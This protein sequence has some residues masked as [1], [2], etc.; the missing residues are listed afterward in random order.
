[1][2]VPF[3]HFFPIQPLYQGKEIRL[4]RE[5]NF[6]TCLAEQMVCVFV[7][8]HTLGNIPAAWEKGAHGNLYTPQLLSH[9]TDYAIASSIYLHKPNHSHFLHKDYLY[10][11][12]ASHDALQ[13]FHDDASTDNTHTI[14]VESLFR[15]RMPLV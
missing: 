6:S 11:Y 8:I 15:L 9:D 4:D 13:I 1:M 5:G 10:N 3:P 7:P 2:A 12:N 14:H